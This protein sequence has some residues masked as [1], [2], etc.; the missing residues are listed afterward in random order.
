[1]GY[2]EMLKLLVKLQDNSDIK[3]DLVGNSKEKTI[4]IKF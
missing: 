1:M 3:F 2:G 4:K